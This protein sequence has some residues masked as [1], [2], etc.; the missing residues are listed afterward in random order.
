MS[1][2]KVQKTP[3]DPTLKYTYY[4]IDFE[5]STFIQRDSEPWDCYYVYIDITFEQLKELYS[6]GLLT[7]ADTQ[8]A[9]EQFPKVFK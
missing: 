7:C 9:K 8:A 5:N 3:F 2:K 4:Y 6:K 1:D